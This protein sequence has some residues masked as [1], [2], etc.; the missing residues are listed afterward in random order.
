M[1]RFAY[2]LAVVVMLINPTKLPGFGPLTH[3]CVAAQNWQQVQEQARQLGGTPNEQML[4]EAL[5]AGALA[6]DL[7]Y[8]YTSDSQLVFLTNLLHYVRTGEFVEFLIGR[9]RQSRDPLLY[10]FS[11]GVMSHYAADRMG[12]YYGT[13]VVA[14]R[15]AGTA[16]LYGER[17]SYERNPNL[18]TA[19]EG[20]FDAMA[21]DQ[22][23]S[24]DVIAER[25]RPF[26]GERS[27]ELGGR[28][29]QFLTSSV[30][31][32]YA[33]KL[34]LSAVEVRE[35]VRLAKSMMLQTLAEG[36]PLYGQ[37]QREPQPLLL[38]AQ[39]EATL[40]E[41]ASKWVSV[42]IKFAHEKLGRDDGQ[43]YANAFHRAN[44]LYRRMLDVAGQELG[45]RTRG[46]PFIDVNLDTNVVSFSGSYALADKTVEQMVAQNNRLTK[47]PPVG[48]WAGDYFKKGQELYRL[49]SETIP[50]GTPNGNI[51]RKLA[52]LE[53]ELARQHS[54]TDDDF[55]MPSGLSAV[56][57]FQKIRSVAAECSN[58]DFLFLQASTHQFCVG[59][60]I[61]HW[62]GTAPAIDVLNA[63]VAA[64]ELEQTNSPV[65]RSTSRI[66][67]D[68]RRRRLEEI[69]LLRLCDPGKQD[70]FF[71]SVY[72]PH[73][74]GADVSR[75]SL[76]SCVSAY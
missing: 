41:A 10:A 1:R 29:A 3:L 42:G 32:F 58:Q 5:F 68:S 34:S 52:P 53:I 65:R 35:A 13:N 50:S 18:H 49:F 19:I 30:G 60:N 45:S 57:F 46:A 14:A 4:R 26:L 9:A 40:M 74:G 72:C 39:E 21:V 56:Q 6:D 73:T 47:C 17:L 7:G 48:G 61:V 25:I 66:V 28:F 44:G 36:N 2:L 69:E 23:C 33:L 11:L 12:H 59:P 22:A 63:G 67:A 62:S 43:T 8:Y 75:Q 38:P 20:A 51:L 55:V 27:L 54:E 70:G 24:P 71:P 64:S 16:S 15:L 31:E 37:E 76:G